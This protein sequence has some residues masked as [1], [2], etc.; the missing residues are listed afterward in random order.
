[1]GRAG[2]EKDDPSAQVASWQ[3][4]FPGVDGLPRG[5]GSHPALRRFWGRGWAVP[6]CP[7]LCMVS[8]GW[9]VL[10]ASCS[11][12]P[13]TPPPYSPGYDLLTLGELHSP[14]LFG[15]LPFGSLDALLLQ[16]R[17]L[18]LTAVISG[19]EANGQTLT[20]CWSLPPGKA[21]FHSSPGRAVLI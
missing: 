2:C 18:A 4:A 13:P 5:L 8:T 19:L 15:T 11:R 20:P 7:S 9:P 14:G 12:S 16:I 17:A 3:R 6:P 1:M 10:L 21:Q